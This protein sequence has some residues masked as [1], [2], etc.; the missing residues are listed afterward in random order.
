LLFRLPLADYQN[1]TISPTRLIQHVELESNS[2]FA[3]PEVLLKMWWQGAR[4]KEVPV[5]FLKR[6]R[7]QATGTRW[8]RIAQSIGE[9]LRCWFHWIVLGR[10]T[11]RRTGTVAAAD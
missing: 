4:F 1:V 5:P 2:S 8:G 6:V 7:G 3:N 10:R 9:I 11:G